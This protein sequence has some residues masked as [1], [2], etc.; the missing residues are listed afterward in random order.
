MK[1]NEILF[2]ILPGWLFILKG[3]YFKGIIYF[4]GFFLTIY[5]IFIAKISL[6]VPS[7]TFVFL[8][9][10]ISLIDSFILYKEY[11]FTIT[12]EELIKITMENTRKV[13]ASL[14][15]YFVKFYNALKTINIDPE[16][17]GKVMKQLSRY[18]LPSDDWKSF[19]NYYKNIYS[20]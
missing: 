17:F 19:I 20:G 11:N 10:L 9:W 15:F 18:E 13:N 8:I 3:Y 14:P 1:K 12:S 7:F 16:A 4:V 5:L 2:A 6:P